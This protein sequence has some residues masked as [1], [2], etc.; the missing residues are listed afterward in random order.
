MKSR[1]IAGVLGTVLLAA[2][3]VSTP[4][5]A[6]PVTPKTV[7]ALTGWQSAAG[8]FELTRQSRVLVEPH[9]TAVHDDAA[10]FAA[11]AKELTGRLLPVV[12]STS[13]GRAGD[14]LVRLDP[15]RA[16]LGAEGYEL[17]VG[18]TASIT[19]K[20]DAGAFYGTRTV[21]QLL[22]AKTIP[23]GH[24]V[25]VPEYAERGVGVCAC[26]INVSTAWFERLVKDA[27][28]LKL[29]QL[30]VELKVKSDT[31]PESV[32]WGYYTKPQL[33]ALQQLADKYHVTIVPEV[34]SPGHIEPWIR[35]RPDLQ[36]TDSSG[37]KQVSRLDITKP[38]AFDFLTDIIDENLSV[39]R[40][41]YWHMGAD[42]YMLGSDY[43]RY[44]QLLAYAQ[45][46][47]GPDA[48]PQ[49]AFVDFINRINAYVKAKGKTLRIW[50]DGITTAA[51]VPLGRD[52]VVEHWLGSGVK[53]SALLADGRKVMNAAYALYNVRGGFKTNPQQLYTSGWSPLKF[54]GETV[55]DRSGI[56]GA[57]ITLWPDNGSGNTENEIEAEVRM[58]LRFVAQATWGTPQPDPDYATFAARADAVGRAPGFDNVNRTPVAAGTYSLTAGGK[59]LGAGAEGDQLTLSGVESAWDVQPTTDGYYTLTNLASGRCAES[60]LGTRYLNTP[61]EPGTAITA[62]TCDAT[63]RLQRWQLAKSGDRITLVNAITRMVAKF[64]GNGLVQQ[65]PDGHSPAP[66]TLAPVIRST[67]VVDRQTITPGTAATLTVTVA[68]TTNSTATDV[69]VTPSVPSGWTVAPSKQ[70]LPTLSPGASNDLAFTVTPPADAPASTVA[71]GAVTSYVQGSQHELATTAGVRL[72]CVPEASSPV[73]VTYV[74]SEETAG[75][76]G[77]A[78]NAIDGNP[79]T[80]WHTEWSATQPPP[81]HEIQL[82][83]GATRSVCAV[84]YQ[85]RLNATN[86]RIADYEIY[87]SADGANWGRPVAKGTFANSP[88]AK[89]V[90]IA[91]TTARYLRLVQLSEATG[92]PF[93]T[94]AEITVDAK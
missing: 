45:Q 67:A 13:A 35:N 50:N 85:T 55:T 72:S 29:N 31:H 52:I 24:V 66:L 93:G 90:P 9:R 57:K 37:Q 89:W 94:A 43:A 82:D 83:L 73:A 53:P 21:L 2:G 5:T 12:R 63:N 25:D 22:K 40:T 68:N 64:D 33:A 38:E 8:T 39:F 34:N 36:L 10:T 41:P 32:E 3:L 17:T 80:F 76:D 77:R 6:Q 26:L 15:A 23:A 81:P 59:Y 47:F 92:N 91:T 16:D 1:L 48:V 86:G 7:P 19:A 69:T 74:D 42:E 20:T 4:A 49:D 56:T 87:L 14:L 65:I 78:V 58:P 11:D 88:D 54:D 46:K 44:P 75:E 70:S 79:A 18:R 71:L 30:W 60:R 62:Q 28:Y 61:L 51:T 27:A 84:T